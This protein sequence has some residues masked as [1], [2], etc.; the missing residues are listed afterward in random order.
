[1]YAA[2]V[3]VVC[4]SAVIDATRESTAMLTNSSIKNDNNDNN[5][6]NNDEKN[7]SNNDLLN[8]PK[9]SI[10]TVLSSDSMNEFVLM[11]PSETPPI[12]LNEQ[13]EID[14]ND[15]QIESKENKK[16]DVAMLEATV[17]QPSSKDRKSVV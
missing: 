6:D 9:T 8:I 10:P 3:Q 2:Y 5:N 4:S 1:M 12:G 15:N 13:D 7:E 17:Q 14:V 16:I 11:S